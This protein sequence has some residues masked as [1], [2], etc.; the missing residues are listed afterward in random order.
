MSLL[1]VVRIW[2][3]LSVLASAAGWI[4]SAFGQ[5]NRGGYFLFF[6]IAVLVSLALRKS[7]AAA[8]KTLERVEDGPGRM[9]IPLKRGV[10]EMRKWLNWRKIRWRLRHGLP[11]WFAALAFLIVLGGALY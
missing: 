4:L 10:I 9:R 7:F 3:W 1:P 2:I 5:L 11:G 8:G 6:A